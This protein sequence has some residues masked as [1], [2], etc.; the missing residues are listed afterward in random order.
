MPW[1][2]FIAEQSSGFSAQKVQAV[3]GKRILTY[4]EAIKEALSQALEVDKNV[5]VLG[6]GVDTAGYIYGTTAG[7]SERFGRERIIE[8]P[9]SES[10][11]AGMALGAAIAGMRPVVVHM[12]N[13]FLLVAMDQIINH[14]SH[15]QG[16]FGGDLPILIR[17][18]V[19]RG[20]GSGA[21]HSQSFQR[22][23]SGFDGLDVVMPYTPYDAKGMFLS[24]I[25][26]RK[27]VIFL[28]HRWLYGDQGYV[29]EEPYF[30]DLHKALIKKPGNDVTVIGMSLTNRDI[31]NADISLMRLGI[32]MEWIDLRSIYPLDM[33]CI[34]TS[35]RKTGRLAIVENGTVH[36]GIGAEITAQICE[37]CFEYLKKPVQR[38]GWK[39]STI[40]AGQALEEK[41][42]P[43]S[44]EIINGI[45]QL[46]S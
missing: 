37:R 14:I 18:V 15:W 34:Y 5:I 3:D 30:T 43:D 45:R 9:V 36:N 20:W 2:K 39:T 40:P 27:P 19:A 21:Q 12:R 31:S 16:I 1:T 29:P 7:A 35:V 44:E 13:D 33:D 32:H 41:A 38:I 8:M 11:A 6:E 10:S 24:A 4:R 25:S 46:M 26:G 17:A 42:Y 28:E 23:F 22:L